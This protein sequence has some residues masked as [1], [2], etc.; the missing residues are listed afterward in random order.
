VEVAV[1]DPA[2]DALFDAWFKVIDAS[3]EPL[4][5]EEPGWQ[6]VELRARLL[7]DC[8]P[9]ERLV[10]LALRDAGG[11]LRAAAW[12][13]LPTY[14][15]RSLAQVSLYVLPEFRR[16]G[17]GTALLGAAEELAVSEGR[18]TMGSW[19]DEPVGQRGSS[20]G[21]AFAGARGYRITQVQPRR[22]LRVP[23]DEAHLGA[24]EAASLPHSDGYRVHTF[25]GPW[26]NVWLEDRV[27]FG[28]RM[29]TDAPRG[30]TSLEDEVWDEARVRAWEAMI[31]ASDRLFLVAVAVLEETGRPVSFTEIAVPRGAPE[32]AYQHDTLVLK[33]HRGHRLGTLVK[34]ANLRVLAE[35]SPA[36]RNVVT[37]NADDNAPM[38]AVNEALGCVVVAD[39]LT[40]EKRI[41]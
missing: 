23:V 40:W 5:P 36:T 11:E 1:L 8:D 17:F 34:L 37:H 32:Q 9:G 22:D 10:P 33:E 27:E 26:P 2:D 16:Q 21:R 28:V 41:V 30:D 14:D 13:E 12:V 18:H 4:W 24:L 15:N 29:S 35:T 7:P 19:Y 38:I 31:E 6:A 3:H 39:N 20:G 25:S